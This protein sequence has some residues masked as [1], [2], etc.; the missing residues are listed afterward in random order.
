MVVSEG[1]AGGQAAARPGLADAVM[2]AVTRHIRDNDLQAG[3]L[4]PSENGLAQD[5]GVS[6]VAVREGFRSL[7]ALKLIDVGNGRRARVARPDGSVLAM[8]L[9]HAVVTDQIS[10]QQIYDVRRTIE[11]RTASLAARHRNERDAAAITALVAS[12]RADFAVPDRVMAHDIAFHEAIAVA[13]RNPA[14]ALIVGAF[15][16]VTR[17]TWAIGWHSRADDRARLEMIAGHEAIAAAII[18]HD[19]DAAAAAMTRHFEQSVQALIVAGVH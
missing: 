3:D 11:A 4:L 9:D 8:V 16:S 17:Q 18:G 12:M 19:P 5:L 13:S 2:D 14:F 10:V 7:A 1:G 15:H 6:R